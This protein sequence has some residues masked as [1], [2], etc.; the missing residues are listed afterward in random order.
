M[1]CFSKD[2]DILKYEPV[3]F[4]E[5]H[6][7]WQV[8]ASGTGGTLSGTTFTAN[9]ADFVSAQVS[10]GQVIY[11]QSTDVLLDGAYEIVSV[12]S[13]TQLNVSVIKA[14]SEDDAVAPPSATDISYRISTFEPQANEAGLAL[15]EYFSI[16]PGDPTS[17]IDLEDVLNADVLKRTSV[18]AV[19]SSV[20]AMLASR[21]ADENFWKKSLYYK[22]L[23]QKARERCRLSIDIDGDGVAEVTKVGSSVR[24][25]RD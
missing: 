4:G 2:V 17:E 8:L 22:R 14:D 11:L 9:D 23:F 5:L 19:V 12:V 6:L 21:A 3:L 20:Y 24:L 7:P 16:K 13:A 10:A 25:A 15:T 1:V 18:F